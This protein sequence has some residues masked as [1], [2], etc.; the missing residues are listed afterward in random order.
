MVFTTTR[1]SVFC[2]ILEFKQFKASAQHNK[3]TNQ[4]GTAKLF[5]WQHGKT[6]INTL[7]SYPVTLPSEF[8]I[9]F[10]HYFFPH[11]CCSIK[12]AGG[13]DLPKLRMGPRHTPHRAAVRLQDNT[14]CKR[15][16]KHTAPSEREG[17][18]IHCRD[19]LP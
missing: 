18:S 14:E 4:G 12:R 3:Q 2:V 11:S 5:F 19:F 8:I 13:Q 15:P 10:S 9:G 17:Y 6:V 1:C 16:Q 7:K